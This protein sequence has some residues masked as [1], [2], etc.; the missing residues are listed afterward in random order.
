[1]LALNG[2]TMGLKPNAERRVFRRKSSERNR[3]NVAEVALT[4]VSKS[5]V[6]RPGESGGAG[7]F[8]KTAPS[9]TAVL[10]QIDLAIADGEFMV[11]VG[12]SGCGK[13]TLLRLIAGLEQLTGG[14]I[15]IGGRQVNQLPPKQRDIAMVFQYDGL[16]QFGVWAAPG[17]KGE[18]MAAAAADHAASPTTCTAANSTPRAVGG[19]IAAAYKT[20]TQTLA[21]LSVRRTSH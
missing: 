4:N 6:A 17:D 15:E 5:Y 3:A 13:S 8:S 16:R 12:P 18:A 11:L 10:K 7:T 14:H 19:A 1:M 20:A 2:G 9:R 21:V